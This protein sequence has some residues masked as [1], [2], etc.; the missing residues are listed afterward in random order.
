M[1]KDEKRQILLQKKKILKVTH[2]KVQSHLL[3]DL[4]W[5]KSNDLYPRDVININTE[6]R[7]KWLFNKSL[8][9]SGI[10]LIFFEIMFRVSSMYNFKQEFPIYTLESRI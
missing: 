2:I 8:L 9:I 7:W 4:K 5:K 6:T 1:I 10:Y 3:F